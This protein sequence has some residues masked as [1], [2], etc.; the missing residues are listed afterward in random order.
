[1]LNNFIS[2]AGLIITSAFF[3]VSE[4][5]LA[6]ARRIKL[7]QL[8]EAGQETANKVISLKEQPGHYFTVVQI[9]LNGVAILGGI[10]GE[11]ALTPYVADILKLWLQSPL[12][13]SVSFAISFA[14]VT[15]LFIL[16][17]DLIPKRLAMMAPERIAVHIVEPMIFFVTVF[18]PLVFIFN[19]LAN[20]LFRLFKIPTTH[21][22]VITPDDIYAVMSAGAEAG[23]LR[24]Q[25]HYLIENV[26]ELDSKTVPSTMTTRDCIIF[27]D[28]VIT[29]Y[30]IHYTK[31]YE[32]AW[33]GG[34]CKHQS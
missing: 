1:M 6:A 10:I 27:F 32:W 17:A 33:F 5:S 14:L 13:E 29:S 9:G 4:I 19:G 30:S 16:F 11:S 18:K 23:V 21:K 7:Q 8:A 31:L 26:F 15:S 25:E 3:S 22:E 20:I 28:C 12:L 24:E 2:I 34:R